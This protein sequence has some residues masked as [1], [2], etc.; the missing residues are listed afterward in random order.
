MDDQEEDEIVSELVR[1][2]Q[3]IKA[4]HS[5]DMFHDPPT[6]IR[7]LSREGLTS[8]QNELLDRIN[9]AFIK[10]WLMCSLN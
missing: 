1:H 9:T 5:A 8:T 2:V 6:L 10:V 7:G 3:N 4:E